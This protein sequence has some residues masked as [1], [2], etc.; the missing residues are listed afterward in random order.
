MEEAGVASWFLDYKG[1]SYTLREYDGRLFE[2]GFCGYT[3]H[4]RNGSSR[5]SKL[6]CRVKMTMEKRPVS[7][8]KLRVSPV[9]QA[10]RTARS[11]DASMPARALPESLPLGVIVSLRQRVL[12]G[13]AEE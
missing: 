8:A 4:T 3:R 2:T 10:P 11:V 6:H 13:G 1:P 12:I 7:S 9:G 5:M